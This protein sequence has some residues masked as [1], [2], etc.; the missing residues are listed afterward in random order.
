MYTPHRRYPPVYKEYLFA[1]TACAGTS[2]AR[3]RSLFCR[4]SWAVAGRRV[5]W[6]GGVAGTLS[7]AAA[8][9]EEK[10]ATDDLVDKLKEYGKIDMEKFNVEDLGKS[11][12]EMIEYGAPGKIGYGFMMGYSSGFCLKK[13]SSLILHE[14]H[15]EVGVEGCSFLV[16]RNVHSNSNTII[17]RIFG[18]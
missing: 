18:G 4:S 6:I 17:A 1:P 13:V 2:Q 11:L 8:L 14:L 10:R 9:C 15:G 5:G 7:T 12:Y 16:R 3:M